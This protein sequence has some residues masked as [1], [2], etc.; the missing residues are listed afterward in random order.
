M[1]E[2]IHEASIEES[3]YQTDNQPC[4]NL[5]SKIAAPKPLLAATGKKKDAT[6]KQ[7]VAP[8][9]KTSTPAKQQQKQLQPQAK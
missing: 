5:R 7:P 3:F 1:N 2:Q 4:Y 8:A 6:A 9:K